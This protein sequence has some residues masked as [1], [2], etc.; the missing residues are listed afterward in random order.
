MT[1][2][3]DES[4][5]SAESAEVDGATDLK[6]NLEIRLLGTFDVRVNGKPL[7]LLRSRKEQWLLALL[8]LRH[9][10]DVSRDWLAATFWPDNDNSQARFYLRK[11]LSNLRKA[12]GPEAYRL[13]SSTT[14]TVRL[15]LSGAFADV[16]VFDAAL[17][18][19]LQTDAQEA[20][21]VAA[22]ALYRGPLLQDCGEEG[23]WL[24]V[25][26]EARVQAYLSALEA[27]AGRA[28]ARGEAAAA[29]R[30]LRLA[31]ALEPYRESAALSLMQALADSGDRAAVRQVYQ[32]LCARLREQLSATPAP[33]TDALYK[34][35][36][37]APSSPE[38][39]P[40]AM[41]ALA[42]PSRR[43][44]P[45]PLTDLLGR[46]SAV[47]EVGVGLDR[48]RLVTLLGP[49]GVGKTRLAI[50]AADAVLLRFPDGVWF[51]GLA[52]LTDPAYVAETTA[53]TLSA[54]Q[55]VGQSVEEGLIAFLAGRSLL[56]VLDN[57]EHLLHSCAVLVDRLLSACP[58][59]RVLST[60]R[61]ALGITGEQVYQVPSLALPPLA[62]L[63]AALDENSAR[64]S[65]LSSLSTE[66]NPAFLQ[67]YA[68][69]ELFVQ[70]A[71]Q[72]N[73]TFRLDRRNAATVCQ[74]CFQLD[75]IP[76]AIE[77]A[78][79]RLRSL[80]VGDIAS[81][82]SDRF[83]LLTGGSRSALPRQQTLRSLIDW[84]YDLLNEAEKALF[85]RLSVFAGGWT[86][87][88][89][90]AVCAGGVVED[91]EVLDLLTSLCD[92]SLAV[93]EPAGMSTRYQFLET[94]RQ[95]SRDRLFESGDI[96]AVRG[97]HR[98]YFVA[99]AEEAEP[100]LTG[101]EQVSWL[102]RL[103]AEHDNLRAVLDACAAPEVNSET[104]AADGEEASAE[105]GLRLAGALAWFWYTRGYLSEGRERGTR[106]L[107]AAPERVPGQGQGQGQELQRFRAKALSGIGSISRSQGD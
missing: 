88:A 79:V 34:R 71:A 66:K 1:A 51:V 35:L 4:A 69:I 23:D 104:K 98:N 31:M 96:E 7:P 107:E 41:P 17:T 55:Q 105:L 65:S 15:D 22:L 67:E 50:A 93:P 44:L 2:E 86:L 87:G 97:R 46:E 91:G 82:L 70:R 30:W 14:L 6:G 8:T 94:V 72:A 11:A 45:V 60:S 99:L 92:K 54:P 100:H 19:P 62:A 75:G 28:L 53:K 74:I 36:S 29:T 59:L 43:H 68:G 56:L 25:E 84:S 78:A 40:K 12:L 24:T 103:E 77:L 102:N 63:S 52:A 33:E 57:C 32:E 10:Q 3:A 16:A 83:R 49:G 95:Y 20:A 21:V 18:H 80:S 37:E 101:P 90:E 85:C 9:D 76:L 106:A 58:G 47:A 39:S 13:K 38:P 61:Q 64:A 81:R 26:R 5:E 73:P 89:A 42:A 48:S 27:V